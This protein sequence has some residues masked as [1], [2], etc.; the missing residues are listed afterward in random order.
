VA[1]KE[2]QFDSH[3]GRD[4]IHAWIHT[5]AAPPRGIL[6][7]VH[8]LGEHSRRYLHLISAALDAGFVVAAD[9]HAGHGATAVAS[10]VWQD[11]G[12]DGVRTVVEDEHSLHD[13]VVAEH[14]GLPYVMF[15]HSWGSMIARGYASKYGHDLAG[16]ALCGIAAQIRGI[17]H[18]LD[19]PALAAAIAEGDGTGDGAVFLAQMFDGFVDRF[20][21]DAVATAWV[22]ADPDVVRDHAADPLNNLGAP[23]SLRFAQDFATLY[24]EVN[25]PAWATTV[26]ADLPVLILAGDQDPVANYGE[27]ALHV[28]NALVAAGRT[29]VTT[30][31]YSGVRHEIHNEPSTRAQVEAALLRFAQDAVA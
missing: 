18:T 20:G 5:P 13:A 6:H 29:D 8:G 3:N 21:P 4:R 25:D 22:A 28:A 1:L 17:E 19:R 12:V 10:G 24:D 23:M 7:I 27:G 15:G 30:H 11:T 2:F 16:L 26:P 31:I 9:D 14:P